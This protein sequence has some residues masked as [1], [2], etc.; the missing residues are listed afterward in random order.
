MAKAATVIED[1]R[2]YR[3]RRNAA[4]PRHI[5]YRS[6]KPLLKF[7]IFVAIASF[8]LIFFSGAGGEIAVRLGVPR[9]TADVVV[10]SAILLLFCPFGFACVGLVLHVFVIL[11]VGIGNGGAPFISFLSK[12]ETGVTFAA[13][14]FLGIGTLVA[15][16]FALADVGVK[17]PLR[18]QGILIA[19]VG[20]TVEEVRQR[21]TLPIREPF[22]TFDGSRKSSEQVVFEF[23]VAGSNLRFPLSR[24]YWIE[25]E[26]NDSHIKVINVGITPRKMPK[27]ELDAFQRTVQAQL[28]ADGWMPGHYLADSE[29]TVRLW[30]GKH[31]SGDGRY[32]LK[33]SAVLI[34]HRNRMDE[35][36]RDEPPNAG[37]YII[38]ISLWPKDFDRELVFEP[39]AWTP[40][41]N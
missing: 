8:V 26:K 36:K 12:H 20:M 5:S 21:S 1:F 9:E 23:R 34:F 11:Q 10:H 19:N 27:R 37:E 6:M 24:Y 18:S 32:W 7:E 41:P 3:W 17:L 30:A 4:A 40:A 14:G 39:S 25:T 35:E 13:W 28:F 22:Q 38:A 16:P 33:G 15:M 29:K 2:L 31:T